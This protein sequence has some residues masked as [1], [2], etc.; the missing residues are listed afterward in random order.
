MKYIKALY[1]SIIGATLPLITYA[2]GYNQFAPFNQFGG[3]Q[4]FGG[5][6]YGGGYT[7]RS[8]PFT[9]IESIIALIQTFLGYAQ[10]FIFLVAI[11]YF[12]F[13]AYLFIS[14]NLAGG[15]TALLYAM[16]GVVI[17]LLAFT[18]IPILCGIFQA[19]GRACSL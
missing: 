9:N 19:G 16:L 15:R 10:V 13:A 1:G 11:G 14:G 3:V 5:G 4:Q 17:G 12:L 7:T 8:V 18:I 2:Q 6:G